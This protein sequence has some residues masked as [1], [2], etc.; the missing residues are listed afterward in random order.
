MP[1]TRPRLSILLSP[2]TEALL[3]AEAERRNCTLNSLVDA[4]V[5]LALRVPAQAAAERDAAARPLP[6]ICPDVHKMSTK[7]DVLI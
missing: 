7:G 4:C 5:R 2:E 6:G 3:R 1:T